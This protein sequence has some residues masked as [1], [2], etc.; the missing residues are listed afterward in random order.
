MAGEQ[1]A[2]QAGLGEVLEDFRTRF[3]DSSRAQKLVKKWNRTILIEATDSTAVYSLVVAQ[4]RI[5]SIDPQRP[6]N[7]DDHLVHLMAPE[8]VLTRIF[9]GHYN[10]SSA[11]LDGVLQAYS[12]DR[13]KVKLEALAMVLWGM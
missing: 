7:D 6:A 4:Q 3:H 11:L 5:V 8:D 2:V 12:N 10:P 1:H 9:A 13:D